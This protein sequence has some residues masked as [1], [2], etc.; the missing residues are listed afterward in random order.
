MEFLNKKGEWEKVP[1]E[2]EEWF[3]EAEEKSMNE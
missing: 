2:V 3:H 1:E